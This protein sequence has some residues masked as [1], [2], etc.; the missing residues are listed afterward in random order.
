MKRLIFLLLTTVCL[1]SACAA[2][3]PQQSSA[4]ATTAITTKPNKETGEDI[5]QVLALSVTE[6]GLPTDRDAVFTRFAHYREIGVTCV[7]IDTAWDS[8]REGVWT[9]REPTQTYLAAAREYGLKLKLILPTVMAPPAWLSAQ[10]GTCLEDQNGRLSVNTVSYWYDGITAYSASA[11]CTQL[12]AIVDGGWS[13]VV[14][15]VVVDMGPAGEPLYP[16]AWTQVADGLDNG[17][18]EEVMWCY[19][20]NAQADFR[21]KMAQKYGDIAAANAAWGTNFAEFS[22]VAVPRPGEAAGT[23]W[24]DT[25][26]WYY[27]AKRAF[28]AAQIDVF[29]AALTEFGLADRP[30]ILYLPGA[31]FAESL[32]ETSIANGTAPTQIK[33][34]CDNRFAAELAAREGCFLQYTGINDAHSLRLLREYMYASGLGEVPV[35]GENAGD[36]NSAS[37]PKALA[38]TVMAQKLTGIDYTHARWLY[39]ADGVTKNAR[40]A[41]FAAAIPVLRAYL[42]TLDLAVAPDF[43]R[44]AGVAAPSGNVLRLDLQFAKPETEPVAFCFVPVKTLRFT[45]EAG[46]TLEYDVKLS[47]DMAGLG[48]VDGSCRNGKTLRD[49]FQMTD[50]LGQRVHPNADLSDYAWPDWSHRTI[51]LGNA[52]SVGETL[53]SLM[54]AAHP[55][56][57]DGL[58]TEIAVTVWYDNIVIKR[59]GEVV[60]EI[61]ID[62]EGFTCRTP[63]NTQYAQGKLTVEPLS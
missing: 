25:L 6:G 4:S 40:F 9:M 19:A 28:M 17:G 55:E 20:A 33:L 32:W 45:I 31:D 27:A 46:D 48:A 30:L 49:S 43:A 47:A 22:A 10:D 3:Q 58:F 39:E 60:C 44:G 52:L 15:A 12:A 18:G 5:M 16:P 7:R 42:E 37:S 23:F 13:D 53:T 34:G 1:L 57:A 59:G 14:C 50:S 56:A 38:E 24:G 29:Q 61:F 51:N 8:P 2:E 62:G 41:E 63:S 35:F 11:I 54:L 36:A 26:S 21:E